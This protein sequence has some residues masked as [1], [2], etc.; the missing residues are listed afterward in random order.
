VQ[1]A[2]NLSARPS[3][4]SLWG[5]KYGKGCKEGV[6]NSRVHFTGIAHRLKT[7]SSSFKVLRF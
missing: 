5:A 6:P 7:K 1:L 4:R 3:R 2:D